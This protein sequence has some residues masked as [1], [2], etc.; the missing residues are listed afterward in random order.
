MYL[1]LAQLPCKVGISKFEMSN[2]LIL[3]LQ[4]LPIFIVADPRVSKNGCDSFDMIIKWVTSRLGLMSLCKRQPF[5]VDKLSKLVTDRQTDRQKNGQTDRQ[6]RKIRTDIQMDR[7]RHR[8]MVKTKKTDKLRD[9]L[10]DEQKE[11]ERHTHTQQLG[12]SLE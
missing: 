2:Q 7:K 6:T 11:K 12:L 9:R 8:K 5:F 4:K 3:F 10:R 1:V